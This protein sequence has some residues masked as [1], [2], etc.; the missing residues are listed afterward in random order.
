MRIKVCGIRRVADAV[1]A[2]RLGVD[3]IGL[4]VGQRHRSEDFLQA[5]Q[6][7]EIA[8]A[9][10][11]FVTPVL[12]THVDDGE[13]VADL[14]REIGVSTI[15][16]H[17][18]C[19]V[20]TMA[21]VRRR[22]PGCKIIRAVHATGDAAIDGMRELE[23]AVDAFVIDSVNVAE[24]RVGGTGLTHDWLLSRRAVSQSRKNVILAGGLR[25]GNV[26][27]AIA[28]VRPYG[29]DA[30]TGLRDANGFKDYYKLA[31]FAEQAK[32]AFFELLRS[33]DAIAY[34]SNR[35]DR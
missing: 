12:V 21:L 26:A 24:D 4:L 20:R 23:E 16:M 7:R 3:A 15:Q 31:S 28:A 14:A 5:D 13:E 9:V 17:S 1:A 35:R 19:D 10:P 32:M 11:P 29:V 33:G 22:I 34:E 8:A 25:P 27:T 18:D 6:A 30:N 2:A